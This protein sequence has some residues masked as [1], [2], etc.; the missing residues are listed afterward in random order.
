MT[1][2]ERSNVTDVV[3]SLVLQLVPVHPGAH[4]HVYAPRVSV[5]V[6][7]FLHT[8]SRQYSAETHTLACN[9]ALTGLCVFAADGTML[10]VE[11]V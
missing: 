4:V 1:S 8:P 3:D 7:P 10:G 2:S 9:Q 6:A 11:R 5:H